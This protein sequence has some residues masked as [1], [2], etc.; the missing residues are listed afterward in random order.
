MYTTKHL[1]IY[2]LLHTSDIESYKVTNIG[3]M[4][5][6]FSTYCKVL[7]LDHIVQLIVIILSLVNWLKIY[8]QCAMTIVEPIWHMLQNIKK[9][10]CIL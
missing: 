10:P 8:S 9:S 3:P 1:F 7:S 6:L 2:S 4:T 5:F